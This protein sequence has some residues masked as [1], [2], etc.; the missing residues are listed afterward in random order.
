MFQ[1]THP[2]GVRHICT[3]EPLPPSGF[4]PRTHTGCDIK[5]CLW[6]GSRVV[7]IHAPT[8]GAT[9]Y[10]NPI[11]ES[12]ILVSIHAPTRGATIISETPESIAR[13]FQ[14]THPHGVR[15][16]HEDRTGHGMVFQSTHPHGVRLYLF[17][18][19]LGCFRRFQSTHP[20]GVRH[21]YA[22]LPESARGCFNPRT[23]TGCDLGIFQGYPGGC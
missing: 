2:H 14:S 7:S 22:D 19:V 15:Q 4:N 9:L 6:R 13:L 12:T 1:S 3:L 18:F 20:H 10:P 21:G 17:G 11:A 8:R 23:H 16:V 5:N